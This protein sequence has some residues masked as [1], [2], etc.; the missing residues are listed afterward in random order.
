MLPALLALSPE[1]LT[2]LEGLIASTATFFGIKELKEHSSDFDLGGGSSYIPLTQSNDLDLTKSSNSLDLS[3]LD[4]SSFNSK[5]NT[6]NVADNI[7]TSVLKDVSSHSVPVLPTVS[8]VPENVP[9]SVENAINLLD[10]LK[11]NSAVL[12][13]SLSVI[14]QDL[15]AQ[16]K[17]QMYES[18]VNAMGMQ[19]IN[20]RLD[21]LLT[22]LVAQNLYLKSIGEKIDNGADKVVTAINEF[23]TAI[24]EKEFQPVI[25][26]NINVDT[27]SV[28]NEISFLRDVLSIVAQNSSSISSTFDDISDN[29]DTIAQAKVLE[30]ENYEYMKTAKTY[31]LSPDSVPALAPRDVLAL[32]EAIKAHLNSQEA[33]LDGS[34]IEDLENDFDTSDVVSQLFNFVGITK[35]IEKFKGDNN[36]S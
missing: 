26:N 9:L 16:F 6:S 36:G 29:I 14:S 11:N 4:N 2:A 34:E 10:V 35:D 27:Q 1:A 31:E 25:N 18:Q 17:A 33:A 19:S 20:V 23:K 21:K 15:V 28:A 5:P 22:L 30:K 32:S 3:S 12:Q 8:I 7:N 13:K 24:K